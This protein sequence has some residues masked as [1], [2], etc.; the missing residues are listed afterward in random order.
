MDFYKESILYAVHVYDCPLK[1]MIDVNVT[2]GWSEV[3]KLD[4]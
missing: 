3:N 4:E 1:S 2:L